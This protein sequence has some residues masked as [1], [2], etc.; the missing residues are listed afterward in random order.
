MNQREKRSYVIDSKTKGEDTWFA[1]FFLKDFIS[2]FLR[3]RAAET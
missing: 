2:F 3:D 1:F